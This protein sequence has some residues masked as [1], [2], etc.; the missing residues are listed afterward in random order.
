[1]KGP[2][3]EGAH[4]NRLEGLAVTAGK[5]GWFVRNVW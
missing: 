2:A 3:E 5:L 4:F 1:M